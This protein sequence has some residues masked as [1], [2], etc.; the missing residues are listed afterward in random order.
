MIFQTRS[1]IKIIPQSFANFHSVLPLFSTYT[2]NNQKAA[3]SSGRKEYE[4]CRNKAFLYVPQRKD[5]RLPYER[6]RSPNLTIY[7]F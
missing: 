5:H 1:S 2:K 6:L 4:P 7:F 3:V